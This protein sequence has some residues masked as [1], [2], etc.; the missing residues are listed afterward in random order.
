MKKLFKFAALGVAALSISLAGCSREEQ[1]SLNIDDIT[2]F[3]TVM[4]TVNFSQG[5]GFQGG[6]FVELTGNPE[7]RVVFIQVPYTALGGSSP[8]TKVFTTVVGADGTFEKEIPLVTATATVT[9]FAEPFR[10]TFSEFDFVNDAGT[11]VFRTTDALY[12]MGPQSI[13]V[14]RNNAHATHLLYGHELLEMDGIRFNSTITLSG[15]AGEM[16]ARDTANQFYRLRAGLRVLV[17]VQYFDAYSNYVTTRI[18]GATTNS[19]GVYTL[20]IPALENG[21]EVLVGIDGIPFAGNFTHFFRNTPTDATLPNTQHAQTVAGLFH[22]DP[23]PWQAVL[24]IPGVTYHLEEAATLSDSRVRFNFSE[25]PSG[26]F[27][28]IPITDA[29]DEFNP[30]LWTGATEFATN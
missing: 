18:F 14:Q 2:T 3:T 12:S 24:A 6:Q 5:Q 8:E 11:P 26:Q 23:T 13:S 30:A 7:G 4:G 25:N 29:R 19:Y 28:D 15:R 9:V 17:E 21:L 20:T 27:A 16:A 22:A 10:A 1:S